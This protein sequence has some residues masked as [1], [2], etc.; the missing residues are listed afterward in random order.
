MAIPDKNDL[1]GS[2]VTESQFKL[3]LGAIV[4][5]LK[6]VENQSPTYAT[7]ALLT[8]TVPSN[9][10]SYAK[11]LDTGK[12][13]AW[14]KPVGAPDGNYWFETE[15][16][17]LDQANKFSVSASDIGKKF[18]FRNFSFFSSKDAPWLY[19]VVGDLANKVLLGFNGK[20]NQMF[21]NGIID[22]KLLHSL[23]L[24]LGANQYPI[25]L[26][27]L[28]KM[29]LGYDAAK[30]SLVGLFPEAVG[31]PKDEAL[32]F[33]LVIKLVNMILAYGQSL[34]TGVGEN[35]VYS[36]TQPY[37]NLTFASGVR[38]NNGDFSGLKPL[39]EDSVKPTPDGEISAGETICSGAANYAS[40]AAYKENGVLPS[41]HVIF[42]STAGHGNYS[43][44]QLSKGTDI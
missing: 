4:D 16:S 41:D 40:L 27:A 1:I 25:V 32:P 31:T 5:F 6:Y 34:S 38:G 44:Q 12:V 8:A 43:I 35:I 29:I 26:D 13:W 20:T 22:P 24:Y 39:V 2:T 11:A 7:T 42:A 14:N 33:E 19:P 21:G 30:D 28:N 37:S 15:L 23:Q 3:N 36:T 17:D 18:Q 10:P 9:S